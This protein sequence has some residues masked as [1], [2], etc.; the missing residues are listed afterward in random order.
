KSVY[1]KLNIVGYRKRQ[2][3]SNLIFR[4]VRDLLKLPSALKHYLKEK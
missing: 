2:L 4:L 3:Y 1:K